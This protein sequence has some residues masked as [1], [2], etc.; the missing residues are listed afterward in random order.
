MSSRTKLVPAIAC[1]VLLAG[2]GYIVTPDAESSP[3]AAIAG[4]W[5]AVAT[6][7][8][9]AAGGMH[10]DVTIRN[11]TGAWSSMQASPDQPAVL[12]T[13][14]GK[15]TDCGTVSIGTGGTSIAP[16]FQIRGYTGGTKL[17]PETQLL[18]V[19][20]AGATPAAGSKLS[21]PY[22]YVTGDFNYYSPATP[23]PGTL[24]VD[25]DAVAADLTYPVAATVEGAVEKADTKIDAINHTTL[26][27]ESAKRAD[28]GMEFAW[29]TDNPT[30]YP[31]YVHI[32]IPPVI[33]S[34]GVIYGY[35]ES[36]HLATPPITPAKQSA[37]WTTSVAVP[38]EVAGLYVLPSVES[39]QQK[40]FTSHA[41][42]IT[43]K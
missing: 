35:Y 2:C 5:A 36:P 29:H 30:S 6:K 9:A 15:S 31:T 3:T 21:I 16:G 25:L 41:I 1:L 12:T 18:S 13:S 7:V 32:G 17:K 23:I 42:D 19:A 10:V 43:D 20:C 34:D 39:K 14:D 40:N 22:A 27:L 26:T 38:K 4:T 24:E 8:D 33:G 37:A 28:D 11:D